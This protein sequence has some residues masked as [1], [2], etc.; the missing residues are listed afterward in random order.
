MLCF[1]FV[2]KAGHHSKAFYMILLLLEILMLGF[3]HRH[4]VRTD[5][6]NF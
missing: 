3:L 1:T 6:N 4:I 2:L 5:L